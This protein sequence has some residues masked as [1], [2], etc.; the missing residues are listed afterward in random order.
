MILLALAT[1]PVTIFFI[2]LVIILLA[3]IL[4]NKL[5]IPHIIGLIAAGVI[6]GPYGLDILDRDSSFLIFG[7]VGLL[8]L[9]FLAG[10][11]IDMFRL[12]MNLRKGLLFGL[13]TFF[14]PMI[15]GILSSVYLLR[16]DWLTSVLLA[17][18]YAAHTLIAYPVVTRFGITKSPAVLIAVVGTI[19][20]VIGSLL[21]IAA[22]VNIHQVGEFRI[23]SVGYLLLKLLAYCIAT[24]YLYPRITRWF[25]KNYSDPVTQFVFVLAMVF[26]SAWVAGMIGLE[27]VLG[28]FFAGLV[29]NRYVPA[30]STLMSR[31]EFVG[32]ALFIPYFL[33][34]VGMMI[35]IQVVTNTST[36]ITTGYM[37]A[38]AILSKWIPAWMAQKINLM[39]G[40]ERRLL[41]GLTSAHT[42]VALA[43]VTIGYNLYDA[44]GNRMMD[45]TILNGTI[46][47]ILITCAIAPI[48]T[49]RAAAK[50]KMKELNEAAMEEDSP[51]STNLLIPIANPVTARSLVEL[52]LLMTSRYTSEKKQNLFALHVRNDNSGSSKAIGRNALDLAKQAAAAADVRIKTIERYDLNIITGITNVMEER[53]INGVILG[54]HRKATVIDSFFGSKVEQLLKSSNRMIII[55][56]SYI[57]LNTISRII[58]SVPENAQF[59]SGFRKWVTTVGNLSHELGCRMIFLSPPAIHGYIRAVLKA[60]NLSVRAE[61]KEMN[62]YDDFIIIANKIH[63]DDLF[64]QVSSRTNAISY[65]PDMAEIPGFLQKYFSS[66]NLMVIY[67]EQFEGDGL[68]TPTFVDPMSTDISSSPSAIYVRLRYFVRAITNFLRKLKGEKSRHKSRIDF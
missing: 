64:I 12:K 68:N 67:P 48:A 40:N 28:A 37:L 46:L 60:E 16:L 11:E 63:D 32:N 44:E 22:V 33:I 26:C 30:G 9:M 5:N 66:N 3:P 7:E 43:V 58:V 15:L 17:S 13:A 14:I 23:S 57:P 34:G 39:D 65:S 41:F 42:A 56:K 50:I 8:Y 27:A 29:L 20:A 54:M 1:N 51:K 38:V 2:V 53:D 21:V 31:I 18:M 45:E 61:Y 10:L 24:L 35:N 19:I 62:S 25:F 55:F 52:G 59:E 36:L 49:A 4:L 6:V 47:V